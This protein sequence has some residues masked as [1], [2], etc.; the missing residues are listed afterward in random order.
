MKKNSNVLFVVIAIVL[1]LSALVIFM[2]VQACRV[3]VGSSISVAASSSPP[4]PIPIE[5]EAP[6]L[7]YQIPPTPSSQELEERIA[8]ADE[9]RKAHGEEIIQIKRQVSVNAIRARMETDEQK[10]K[11]QA[12]PAQVA[13]GG[14]ATTKAK[15]DSFVTPKTP[16]PTREERKKMESRGI[17]SF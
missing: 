2:F 15:I 10:D 6:H 17:I 16:L 4:L 3:T 14:A 9:E 5:G 11:A 1:L 12:K 8:K 13:T 7:G